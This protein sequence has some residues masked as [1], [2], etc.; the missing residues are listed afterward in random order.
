MPMEPVIQLA[1]D[2]LNIE[3]ALRVAREAVPAGVDWVEAG[4]PLIKAEGLEA[5]RRLRAEFPDKTI[6]AD[7]KVMDAG[8]IEVEAA[9]K[10]G[11]NI[12]DVLGQASDETI[13]ECIEA[14]ENYGA[15]IVVDLIAVANPV[16]RATQIA[17]LGPHA[18]AVHTG[19][20]EQMH[21]RSGFET[22]AT[23]AKRID[24]PLAVAGGINSQ[25]CVQAV[26]SGASIVI[27]GGAIT[28]SPDARKATE[29]I[30]RAITTRKA[31]ASELFQRVGEEKLV[32]VFRRVNTADISMAMHNAREI[33]GVRPIQSGFKLVGPAFTVRTASGDWAKPVEA[34][35]RAKPGD[36]IVIDAGGR[37]PAIWGELATHSCQTKKIAGVV[38]D[39]AIRDTV[40]IKKMGFPAFAKCIAPAAGDPKGLGEMDVPIVVGHRHVRPGDWI[41]GDDDGVIVVPK[42]EAVEI[43]NRAQDVLERENRIRA[44]IDAGSTLASVVELDKWEKRT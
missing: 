14:G 29:E 24:T 10:A 38:I 17:K 33:E 13:A 9:A 11:A 12:V 36:V 39:G 6:V 31:V 26:E 40:E 27:V 28:K 42:A 3:Q 7:M 1:L 18:I 34:I 44:E 2:F 16:E 35:D 4:T 19:I 21:A 20:D 37:P 30:K 5:V 22:L 41:V 25:T 43:A 32:E 15:R 23:I 8:R